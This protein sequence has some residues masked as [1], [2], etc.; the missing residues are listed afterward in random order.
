MPLC[1]GAQ[2]LLENM[3]YLLVAIILYL[4]WL[5][6][7]GHFSPLLLSL[8]VVSA[9]LS[10]WLL[11]RMDR[12]DKTPVGV[13]PGLALLNYGFWLLWELVKAN[14]NVARRIWDPALPVEPGWVR[15]PVNVSS[16]LQK[17]LYA[18]SITLTP[19]TLT[20]DVCEDYFLVHYLCKQGIE[21]LRKGEMERRIRRTGI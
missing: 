16:P 12:V 15:L 7:S 8:G 18:N 2:W 10:A 11:W 3:H 19:G 6:L 17:A 4:F 1:H 13:F 9:L 21:E 5:I 20:A 14:I